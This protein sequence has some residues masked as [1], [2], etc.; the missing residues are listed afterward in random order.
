MKAKERWED[1]ANMAAG[2]WLFATPWVFHTMSNPAIL[3]NSWLSGGAIA[4]V[5]LWALANPESAVT[6]LT[7]GGLA[8]WTF[9]APWVLHFSNPSVVAWNTRIVAM[10]VGVLALMALYDQDQDLHVRPGSQSPAR[11]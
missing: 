4:L 1:L 7:N 10:V 9:F 8:A 6:E 11:S 3:W 2:A 5:A